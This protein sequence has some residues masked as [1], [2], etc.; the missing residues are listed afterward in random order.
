MIHCFPHQI[1]E[2]LPPQCDMCQPA[3][4]EHAASCI[5]SVPLKRQKKTQKTCNN[6]SIGNCIVILVLVKKKSNENRQKRNLL[7]SLVC[8]IDVSSVFSSE[9]ATSETAN[10]DDPDSK[11]RKL[12]EKAK[13]PLMPFG[14]DLHYWGEDQPSAGKILK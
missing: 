8:C 12:E 2:L 13:A 1:S 14:L 11:R 7:W 9:S 6:I 3:L 10:V 4:A 5:E